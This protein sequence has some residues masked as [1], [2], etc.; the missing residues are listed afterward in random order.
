MTRWIVATV[1]TFGLMFVAAIYAKKYSMGNKTPFKNTV[2]RMRILETLHIDAKH[3]VV[4]F[5]QDNKEHTILIGP[6]SQSVIE[7]SRTHKTTTSTDT[8]A[9]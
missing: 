3:K 1:I 7:S 4:I 5:K 9:E 8:D 6:N 2:R